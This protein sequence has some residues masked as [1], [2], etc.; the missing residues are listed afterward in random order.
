METAVIP[1]PLPI[2]QLAWVRPYAPEGWTPDRCAPVDHADGGRSHLRVHPGLAQAWRRAA[3]LMEHG[4]CRRVV[5]G[6][7]DAGERVGLQVVQVIWH[8]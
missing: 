1:T 2:E 5:I 4:L 3:L 6:V 8:D 7:V